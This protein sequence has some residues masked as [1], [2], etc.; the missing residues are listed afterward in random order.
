MDR[1]TTVNPK[2]C[3]PSLM[4]VIVQACN[5]VTAVKSISQ[6]VEPGIFVSVC[7]GMDVIFTWSCLAR[8]G[9]AKPVTSV[10]AQGPPVTSHTFSAPTVDGTG[11]GGGGLCRSL[12]QICLSIFLQNLRRTDEYASLRP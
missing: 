11:G 12:A 4:E 8:R 1:N 7:V 3:L 5:N 9:E 2:S 10:F 6:C